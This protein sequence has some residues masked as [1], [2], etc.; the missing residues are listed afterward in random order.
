MTEPKVSLGGSWETW[1]TSVEPERML[2]RFRSRGRT[3][4]LRLF[5]CGCLRRVWHL[6]VD[7]RSK[8]ALEAAE[9]H[10]LGSLGEQE[11]L[12]AR[13]AALA[14]PDGG[15]PLELASRALK[16]MLLVPLAGPQVGPAA[17]ETAW[18][19]AQAVASD[20]R[21][22]LAR[23]R[24]AQAAL[25]RCVFGNPFRPAL[26][27]LAC[28]ALEVLVLAHRARDAWEFRLLPALADTLERAGCRCAPLLEHCRSEAIHT[29]GCHALEI[30]LGQT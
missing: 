27:G 20:D 8:R 7:E 14:V 9:R 12:E 25:V 21:E 11:Y 10:A 16:A 1:E 2:R 5:A 6:L 13:T 18:L 30:L 22:L 4:Q 23:E 29:P 28:R 19:A 17:V 3:R 15:G 24:A 26:P